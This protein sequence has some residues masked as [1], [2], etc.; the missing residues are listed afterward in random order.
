MTQFDPFIAVLIALFSAVITIGGWLFSKAWPQIR[1]VSH[2][3]DDL[4][5]EP[6]R[7]GVPARPGIMERL[8]S[9]EDEVREVKAQV[10]NSH[11]TN[12]RDDIDRVQKSLAEHIE[13]S[14]PI[15]AKVDDLHAHYVKSPKP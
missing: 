9:V 7:P 12:L 13:E 10:K 5:G 4:A 15:R 3:V 2:F 6:E 14:G 8:A 1:K 11:S